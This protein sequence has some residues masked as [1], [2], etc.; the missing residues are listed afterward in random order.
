MLRHDFRR[1]AIRNVE[2][3]GVPLSEATKVSGHR[4]ESV[5]R[6]YAI[7]SDGDLLEASQKLETQSSLIVG[8]QPSDQ[9]RANG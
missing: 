5:Y 4:S 9:E 1:T 8:S 6:R 7:V 2:R 3:V